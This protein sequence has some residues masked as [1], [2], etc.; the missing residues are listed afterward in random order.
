M[1]VLSVLLYP[2]ALIFRIATGIR[3]HLYSI[4]HKRSFRFEIP[5]ISVGNLS[6]GGSGKT[7]AIEYLIR[8]LKNEHH[9]ATLSRGYGRRTK[10]LRFATDNDS[11]STI[12]DEPFQFYR[13]YGSDLHVVV[14]EDRAFAIPNILHQYPETSVI[15]LDDAFQHRSVNP[16]LSILLT[17]YEKPFYKDYL[18]PMGRLRESRS[19]AKRADAIIITK[20]PKDLSLAAQGEMRNNIKRY[21]RDVPVF[22]SFITYGKPIPFLDTK[23]LISS[24]VVLVS[25]IARNKPLENYVACQFELVKH[26][27]FKDHHSYTVKDVA[28]LRHHLKTQI[29]EVSLLTTEKDMVRF[30]D[31]KFKQLLNDLPCYYLPIEMNF[32]NN[33]AEFDAQVFKAIEAAIAQSNLANE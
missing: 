27:R 20:C 18:L 10:G 19:G 12:G 22:F 28:A 16:H 15:L 23:A 17:Y 26:F 7:P 33:G 3:N 8:L 2:F 14:G 24:K 30:L 1:G 21:A 9:I 5:V 25:G 4:G 29:A 6:L 11:A 31:P 13:K 32:I